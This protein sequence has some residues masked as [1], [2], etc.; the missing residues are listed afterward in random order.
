MRTK[1]SLLL[2]YENET[3]V[4]FLSLFNPFTCVLHLIPSGPLKDYT[5]AVPNSLHMSSSQSVICQPLSIA[6]TPKLFS[7]QFSPPIHPLTISKNLP[8]IL[9]SSHSPLVLQISHKCLPILPS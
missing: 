7:P 8:V 1:S 9:G 6:E 2:N 5:P 3:T 4:T